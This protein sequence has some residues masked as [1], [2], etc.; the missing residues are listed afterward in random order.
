MSDYLK[1]R[2][3]GRATVEVAEPLSSRANPP[4]RPLCRSREEFT[5]NLAGILKGALPAT[6]IKTDAGL[7]ADFLSPFVDVCV[8]QGLVEWV[9]CGA[10]WRL[11]RTE[12]GEKVLS[13]DSP[14][15]TARTVDD[16]VPVIL[17]ILR[18]M[19]HD[20]TCLGDPRSLGGYRVTGEGLKEWAIQ[21]GVS[22]SVYD[23][24][25]RMILGRGWA[26]CDGGLYVDFEGFDTNYHFG[27]T[28]DG[29]AFLRGE[30]TTTPPE[31]TNGEPS[32]SPD[33]TSVVWYGT[34]YTFAKGNQAQAVRVLWEAWESGGHSLTQ[35][36]IGEKIESLAGRFELAKT[37]R[38]HKH[39]G[40]YQI[41]PAWRTMIRQDSKGSYRLV[42]PE[43]A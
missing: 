37:F 26:V 14:D 1:C 29:E 32:H 4:Q 41:H 28:P 34:R 3:I 40:G 15:A 30:F 10:G 35:E 12:R 13:P 11:F 42:P 31:H 22:P 33:F 5:E 43:S 7:D 6:G 38:K 39:G 25:F 17:G 16:A 23:D 36:T 9:Q 8:E 20:R 21:A 18:D 2:G 19:K 27:I 24:A